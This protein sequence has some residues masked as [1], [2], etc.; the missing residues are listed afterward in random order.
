MHNI[1]RALSQN[2]T[3]F[4]DGKVHSMPG[5]E[6]KFNHNH[7]WYWL[8]YGC[9]LCDPLP[10]TLFHLMFIGWWVFTLWLWTTNMAETAGRSSESQC[11]KIERSNWKRNSWLS[12]RLMSVH[13]G[14]DQAKLLQVSFN[15]I[16]KIETGN[17]VFHLITAPLYRS[18]KS[19]NNCK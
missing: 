13:C 18:A 4:R 1:I 16:W 15:W 8:K 17:I 19:T 12:V 10:S 3:K 2:Y 6:G 11:S 5:M 9:R 7:R 14:N